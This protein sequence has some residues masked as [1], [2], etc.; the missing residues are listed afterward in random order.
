MDVGVGLTSA[1]FSID[2]AI[3]SR[4]SIG[5][6]LHQ[7]HQTIL[8][9][10]NELRD[11]RKFVHQSMDRYSDAERRISHL[12]AD[13]PTVN[14]VQNDSLLDDILDFLDDT[15][16]DA[17]DLADAAWD[18]TT[19]FLETAWDLIEEIT[20]DLISHV[21]ELAE[22]VVSFMHDTI[23]AALED[24][25]NMIEAGWLHIQ[26]FVTDTVQ[27][28]IDLAGAAFDYVIEGM[29]DA[30]DA[31]EAAWEALEDINW[32]DLGEGFKNIIDG[33]LEIGLGFTVISISGAATIFSAGT[34]APVAW[35]GAFGGGYMLVDG[36]NKFI[37]GFLEILDTLKIIDTPEIPNIIE[38]GH[39]FLFG[40]EVGKNIYT[41]EQ[42]AIGIVSFRNMASTVG[43]VIGKGGFH[44]YKLLFEKGFD[45]YQFGENLYN[46][47]DRW[48]DYK[49]KDKKEQKRG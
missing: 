2:S 28:A 38:E 46:Y 47:G 39:K 27:N 32:A 12:V 3:T 18:L 42:L 41:A 43:D 30:W 34:A 26:E 44:I 4:R 5:Q 40:E 20:G 1:R 23:T 49:E 33:V 13:L 14:D 36:S 21:A 19:E 24:L 25:A 6:R 22:D 8:E 37:T 29:E 7:S 9:L 31:I 16:Q 11:L 10:E 48:L 45:S 35:I 17:T 15:W